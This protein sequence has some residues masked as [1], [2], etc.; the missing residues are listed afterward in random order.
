MGPLVVKEKK[1][2]KGMGGG[3]Q[4]IGDKKDERGV[5]GMK[6]M[7][8]WIGAG[9]GTINTQDVSKALWKPTVL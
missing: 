9:G 8:G 6:F 2:L 5:I 7:W 1:D 3:D 4:N